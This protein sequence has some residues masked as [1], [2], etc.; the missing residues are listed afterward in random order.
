MKTLLK[1][2][3]R[4]SL[5]KRLTLYFILFG[6]IIGYIVF[7]G[8]MMVTTHGLISF[9]STGIVE[10]QFSDYFNSAVPDIWLASA[11]SQETTLEQKLKALRKL[12]SALKVFDLNAF[13]IY[14]R[15]QKI[16]NKLA[17][18]SDGSLDSV[19]AADGEITRLEKAAKH[20][21]RLFGDFYFGKADV[22]TI[23]INVTRDT[24]NNIYILA[25]DVWREDIFSFIKANFAPGSD[26]KSNG[27]CIFAVSRQ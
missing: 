11:D 10:Q 21:H 16:W 1:K 23:M 27:H 20:K 18:T 5:S 26:A 15:E 7:I 22:S 9:I 2:C 3:F 8:S 13:F 4:F 12:T 14:R 17:F 25:F 24:D 19:P 6:L